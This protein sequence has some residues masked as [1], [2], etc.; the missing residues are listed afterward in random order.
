MSKL[1]E[2]DIVNVGDGTYSTSGIAVGVEYTGFL[3]L[4]TE[5]RLSL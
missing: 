4:L 5:I 3:T 2:D 1:N